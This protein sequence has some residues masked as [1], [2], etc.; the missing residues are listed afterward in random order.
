MCPAHAQHFAARTKGALPENRL[1]KWSAGFTLAKV[2][3]GVSFL[4][5]GQFRKW[6]ESVLEALSYTPGRRE[7]G[8]RAGDARPPRC[9][10]GGLLFCCGGSSR[11]SR[12]V[13]SLACSLAN[14]KS[15]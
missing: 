3:K 15:L 6:I 11:N 2:F 7:G 13:L 14:L 12:N 8:R 10:R 9:F 4:D 1:M 5:L